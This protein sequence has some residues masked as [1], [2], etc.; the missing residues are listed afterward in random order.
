MTTYSEENYLAT[1]L[2]SIGLSPVW[3]EVAEKIGMEAFL[4]MWETLSKC[5]QCKD[6]KNYIYIPQFS[7][8][9]RYLRNRFIRELVEQKFSPLDIQSQVKETF[10]ER[11]SV[12]HI[13]RIVGEV[14]RAQAY[15]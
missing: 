3:V 13:R 8:W 12:V 5:E 11:L 14:R 10:D 9:K 1:R 6:E 2:R 4:Q 7:T 15:R